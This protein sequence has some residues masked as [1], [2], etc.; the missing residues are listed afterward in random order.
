MGGE[1]NKIQS[2]NQA[3]TLSDD[4]RRALETN[5]HEKQ[6]D[7]H[8]ER[9]HEHSRDSKKEAER[10]HVEALE[11]ANT[12]ERSSLADERVAKTAERRKDIP[13]KHEK[14][15]AYDSLMTD[16]RAHM[17]PTSQAFSKVI[18]NP[19][20]EA[21]SDA[22]GKTIAR[23]NAILAGSFTAFALTL[24]VYLVARYYGYELSGFETI[25]T[26]IVGWIIGL[27][28]DYFKHMATGGRS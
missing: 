2:D 15:Q 26:F 18:H 5:A 28:A 17:T 9:S 7:Q 21:V 23:P 3:E 25:A 13:S 1:K 6:R 27:V 22:A 8:A 16:A 11:H 4:E 19:A 20:I 10:A 12:S 24:I 14:Q